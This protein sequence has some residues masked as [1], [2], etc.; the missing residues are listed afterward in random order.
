MTHSVRGLLHV[1]KY[2]IQE[3]GK[4]VYIGLHIGIFCGVVGIGGACGENE[5]LGGI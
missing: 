4:L 5:A 2:R 1:Y 3:T